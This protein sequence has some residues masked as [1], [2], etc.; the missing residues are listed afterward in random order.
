[1]SVVQLRAMEITLDLEFVRSILQGE[2]L[3][4]SQEISARGVQQAYEASH[5]RHDARIASAPDAATLA[6]RAGCS[7]CCYF[8]VDV[9]PVE[10]YR[11]LDFVQRE[12]N[13]EQRRRVFD[14]VKANGDAL[15]GLD[16]V[17]RARRNIKCAFLMD[18]RCSIYA[19]R[20]Q[21]CRNYHAT[22]AVG[23]ERSYLEPDNLEID[24]EFAPYVYQAGG[25]HVEAFSRAMQDAGYDT[26]VY[27]LNGAL[28]AA[29]SQ[30][31]ALARF[32]SKEAPFAGLHGWDVPPEFD[33]EE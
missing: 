12:F 21:M 13:A 16:D 18:G 23:C 22:N 5:E 20:P 29:R 30:P 3:R 25:A 33:E 14:E 4:A 32:E 8:S 7:W 24:P 28:M 6:C 1:M 17:E 26:R 9:R 15:R 27:E 2:Y 11:I 10:V 19:A 31:D